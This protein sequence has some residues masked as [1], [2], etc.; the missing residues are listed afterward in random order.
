MKDK[1]MLDEAAERAS[2]WGFNL[3]DGLHPC[4]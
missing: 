4:F 3:K 1:I 2:I